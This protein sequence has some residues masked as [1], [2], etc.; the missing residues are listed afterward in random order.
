MNVEVFALCDAATDSQG[1]LNILGTF[2]SIWAAAIP[3][4]HPQCSVAVRLRFSRIEEG[5]HKVV[6][7]L[8]DE[9]GKLLMPPL[10]ANLQI[11]FGENDPT[12]VANLVLNIQGLNI[13]KYG[14]YSV[15]LAVD[16]RQEASLP[17]FVRKPNN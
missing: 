3:T 10:D 15:I 12:A 9:D 4:R 8:V 17:F 1:K 13:E 14:E 2:D 5:D 11:R 16:G 7:H 6:L